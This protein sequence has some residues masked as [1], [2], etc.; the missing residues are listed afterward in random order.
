MTGER[1]YFDGMSQAVE[2]VGAPCVGMLY[3]KV[4]WLEADEYG[5]LQEHL[6]YTTN[7]M[8]PEKA[9]DLG[10]LFREVADG[11]DPRGAK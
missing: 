7:Y 4:Y 11:I 8:T 3:F 6:R 5:D 9:R 1:I 2:V 10:N